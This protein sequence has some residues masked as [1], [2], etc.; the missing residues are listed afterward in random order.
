AA[1]RWRWSGAWT[2]KGMREEAQRAML[3]D[4]D[5]IPSWRERARQTS[6]CEP[7]GAMPPG[8]EWHAFNMQFTMGYWRGDPL[9]Q[10]A[11]FVEPLLS[12]P[13]VETCLQIPTYTLI[14]RGVR[15]GLARAT[16]ARLLSP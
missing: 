16:F 8:K 15:R 14:R 13:V 4:P 2:P 12:Q 1:A 11:D 5:A 6:W 9:A 7:R 3:T 10:Y